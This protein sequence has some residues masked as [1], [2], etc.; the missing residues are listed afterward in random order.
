M[1]L[2]TQLARLLGVA[3][4]RRGIRRFQTIIAS[5]NQAGLRLMRTLS[6]H[7]HMGRHDHGV[8]EMVMELA[9]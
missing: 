7:L 1:G 5:D 8:R 4:R 2:G 9:A 6:F 3:A